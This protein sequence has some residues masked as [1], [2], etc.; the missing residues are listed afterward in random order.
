MNA[1]AS[2]RPE[3]HS[4]A[5]ERDAMQAPA[6][7]VLVLKS[8]RSAA[9]A[10][11]REVL[12][13]WPDASVAEV[14]T[15][16]AARARLALERIDWLVT[17]LSCD[18]GDTHELVRDAGTRRSARVVVH[19]GNCTPR[20]IDWLMTWPVGGIFESRAEPADGLRSVLQV[21]DGG[22]RYLSENVRWMRARREQ[23]GLTVIRALSA[24]EQMVLALVASAHPLKEVAADMDMTLDGLRDVLRRLHAKLGVHDTAQLISEALRLGFVRPAARGLAPVG[25][26]LLREAWWA[27]RGKF[28]PAANRGAAGSTPPI[29]PE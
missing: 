22:G 7:S 1:R 4:V 21:V 9:E 23:S 11:R 14:R 3:S 24:T 8:N 10:I 17:G 16:E 27:A 15:L 12:I 25:L 13:C 29:F 5:S 20:A 26:P 19:T 18:D 2:I 28:R 6:R